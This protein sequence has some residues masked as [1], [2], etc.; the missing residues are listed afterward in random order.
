MLG[1]DSSHGGRAVLGRV[2][3][4][5]PMPGGCRA[6]SAPAA[7]PAQRPLLLLSASLPRDGLTMATF[8]CWA[9]R[10]CHYALGRARPPCSARSQ[11]R[12][13][14]GRDRFRRPRRLPHTSLGTSRNQS[15]LPEGEG[16]LLS[17]RRR[18]PPVTPDGAH[19]DPKPFCRGW[20][21][22]HWTFAGLQVPDLGQRVG[23]GERPQPCAGA[24][25]G[26]AP[27]L[28]LACL[29]KGYGLA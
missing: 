29:P 9:Q 7:D 8:V 14:G 13:P 2:R 11:G 23:S 17:A 5:T 24:G 19:G 3:G 16:T 6:I 20:L 1:L 25:G 10:R 18:S 28:R 27:P 21:C 26:G 12:A 22:G 15:L 4:G